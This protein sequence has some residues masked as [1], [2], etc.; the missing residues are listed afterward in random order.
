MDGLLHQVS[1]R[2]ALNY[3]RVWEQAS[4]DDKQNT[5]SKNPALTW[6][7]IRHD[8]KSGSTLTQEKTREQPEEANGVHRRGNGQ[9]QSDETVRCER[10][11]NQKVLRTKTQGARETN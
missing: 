10:S 4:E 9:Q 7:R 6:Q 11:V 2:R 5:G 3:D 1:V 8:G